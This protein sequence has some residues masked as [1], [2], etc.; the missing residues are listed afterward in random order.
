MEEAT[1]AARSMEEQAHALAESV[2]V[3][4]LEARAKAG[5]LVRVT[6]PALR[7]A[8]PQAAP[9]VSVRKPAARKHEPAFAEGDWQEF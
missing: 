7:P 5:S 3:F 6:A 9:A 1:A 4:K 8:D 2:A